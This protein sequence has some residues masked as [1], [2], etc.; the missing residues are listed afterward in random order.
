MKALRK[1]PAERYATVDALG[2]DLARW[3]RNEPILARRDHLA[4]RAAKFVRRHWAALAVAGAFVLA[5]MSG[6]VATSYEA[7][8]AAR[9]RDA[10][11]RAQL[12]SL[13]Q[14]AAR[15]PEGGR[16]GRRA[17]H[18]SECCG[19]S[20]RRAADPSAALAVFQEARA[21]DSQP[22]A[23]TVGMRLPVRQLGEHRLFT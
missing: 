16:C 19:G 10:A 14:T 3:L 8:V 13:T 5:L 17:G 11:L 23:L 7:R 1:H 15:A 12:Q 22:L 2:E 6:L 18:R 4:Y 21:A 9:Q 20:S